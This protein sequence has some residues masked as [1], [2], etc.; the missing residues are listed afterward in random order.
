MWVLNFNFQSIPGYSS[1]AAVLV[2]RFIILVMLWL[3]ISSPFA[4]AGALFQSSPSAP[5]SF[6][7]E[8][9][10]DFGLPDLDGK[11]VTLSDLRGKV[12]LLT[13]WASWCPPCR[14]EMPSMNRLYLTLRG[15]EFTVLGVNIETNPAAARRF[16]D[17]LE[18]AFPVLL[19]SATKVRNQYRIYNIPQSFLVDKN[20]RIVKHLVGYHDWMSEASLEMVKSLIRNP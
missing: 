14:Q 3:V 19:D 8:P 17:D 1:S 20:G 7:G 13:F 12:V 18:L 10:P 15:E 9:A 5:S 2:F 11:S 16:V 6:A 4:W